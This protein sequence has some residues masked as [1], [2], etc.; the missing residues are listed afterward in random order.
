MFG[1][2][3]NG[4]TAMQQQAFFAIDIGDIRLACRGG[5]KAWIVSKYAVFAQCADINNIVAQRA[6]QHGQLNWLSVVIKSNGGF[7]RFGCHGVIFKYF[8][9]II[10]KDLA[11]GSHNIVRYCIRL[12]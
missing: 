7:G 4:V 6:R 1:Q 10:R 11:K 9:K 3:L 12:A 8:Y 5:H 2:L